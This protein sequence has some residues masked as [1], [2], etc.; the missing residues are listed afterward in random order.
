MEP[1]HRNHSAS[2]L[3]LA[4]KLEMYY[5]HRKSQVR[6]DLS[7]S[8][9]DTLNVCSLELPVAAYISLMHRSSLR[10]PDFRDLFL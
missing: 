1:L 8:F 7:K 2:S 10:K 3:C 4:I 5:R 6:R 9:V